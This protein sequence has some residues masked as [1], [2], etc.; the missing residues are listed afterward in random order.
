MDGITGSK[1]L[2]SVVLAALSGACYAVFRVMFRKMMGDPPPVG[3]I[4]FTFTIIGI[5][6]AAMLWPVCLILYFSDVEKMPLETLTFTVL[7]I[8]STLLLSFH[9]LTQ[10]SGA[11]TYQMFVTLGLITSVPVSA[12]KCIM[13]GWLIMIDCHVVLRYSVRHSS[14]W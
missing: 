13:H 11:V 5:I 6:N 4:A 14:V 3:R 12:C 7:M 8:A 2:A 10:F 1:T 9:I